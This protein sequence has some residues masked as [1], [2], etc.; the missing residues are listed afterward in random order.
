MTDQD[1]QLETAEPLTGDELRRHAL[2]EWKKRMQ[3][4]GPL[5]LSQPG[6]RELVHELQIHQIELEMQNEELRRV[7]DE[8]DEARARYFDLFDL[9]PV[10]YC[11]LSQKGLILEANL[12]AAS[13][14][15]VERSTL[16][17]QPISHF[18]AREDQD[19]Y[20]L[21]RK[22]LF[23]TGKPQTFELQM[24]K[25]DGAPFWV[26][27]DAT[28][29]QDANGV[30][31][32]R[33]TMTNISLRKQ[34]EAELLLMKEALGMANQKLQI[35]LAREKELSN[36]DVLTS[37]C[38]RR[39]FFEIAAN[40]FYAAARY[41]HPL[42][43]ML[44]DVDDFKQVNDT[45]GHAAGDKALQHVALAA[46]G[47]LRMI[48]VLAR[49]GGDEFIILLPQTSTQDAFPLAERIRESVAAQR[50]ASDKGV[51]S[52][53]ISIG[54]AE[55]RHTLDGETIESIIQR[56]DKAMYASKAVGRNHTSIYS[57]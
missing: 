20:Y 47:Q 32:C 54:I 27:M 31:V 42:T 15:G 41:E 10:G 26:Y 43:I 46:A 34:E 51:F 48:D 17:K 57:E 44:F 50:I 11:T 56:A 19:I 6:M 36:T 7:Q 13:M 40:E 24:L 3:K 25:K 35:A 8:L 5:P 53:S 16:V 30:P 37:L 23:G 22:H 55:M 38:N 9:A 52:V 4:T 29:V 28:T 39:H 18:I 33:I 14:L 49:Y 12:T 2:N 21:H 1:N 45:L